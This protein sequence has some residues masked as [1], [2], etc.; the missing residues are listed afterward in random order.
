MKVIATRNFSNGLDLSKS[1]ITGP[2]TKRKFVRKTYEAGK[3]YDVKEDEI[4]EA[5]HFGWLKPA[6]AG[7]AKEAKEGE[8]VTKSKTK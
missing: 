1:T 2:R 5:L 8:V 6:A 3:T 4:Q 7:S